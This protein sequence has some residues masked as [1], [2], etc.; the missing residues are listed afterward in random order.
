M[1]EAG[2]TELLDRIALGD[3]GAR[4]HLLGVVYEELRALAAAACASGER[5]LTLQPTALLHE[6]WLKLDG[7]LAGFE[8]RKHF[9]VVAAKAMRQV[10]V[11][12]ARARRSQKRGGDRSRVA[13]DDDLPT[14]AGSAPDLVHLDDCLRRLAELNER[15][16][17]VVELRF[18]GALTIAETAEVLGVSHGTVENDW[19]MARAWLRRELAGS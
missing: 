1:A 18:L 10:L 13:L 11:D 5:Q 2:V 4:D 17:R 14:V 15:H 3:D 8:G 19:S 16:A 6:A 7:A 9:F 12:H